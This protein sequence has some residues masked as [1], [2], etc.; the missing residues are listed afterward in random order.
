MST[1]IS[2]GPFQALTPMQIATLEKL[3]TSR[4][5]AD[6]AKAAGISRQAI[7]TW[8]ADPI[9]K[10]ALISIYQARFDELNAE[11]VRLGSKAFSTLETTMDSPTAPDWLKA[12]VA[13]DILSFMLRINE[14]TNVSLKLDMLAQRLEAI[15]G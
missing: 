9:F 15:N 5:V 10:A 4:T 13:A 12:R 11:A 2:A 3:T 1:E 8:M 7:Y 6:A 14:S